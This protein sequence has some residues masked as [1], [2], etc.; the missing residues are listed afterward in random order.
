MKMMSRLYERATENDSECEF[1]G[2][3]LLP[4]FTRPIDGYGHERYVNRT[5]VFCEGCATSAIV[6][7]L[8]SSGRLPSPD[9]TDALNNRHLLLAI[10]GSTRRG[11]ETDLE[12]QLAYWTPER[13]EE[14]LQSRRGARGEL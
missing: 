9:Q 10:L 6:A 13:V 2:G 12:K 1:C 5:L 11:P 14:L 7:T 3:S 8:I 4:L